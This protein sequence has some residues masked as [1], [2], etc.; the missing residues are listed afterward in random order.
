MTDIA[1]GEWGFDGFFISDDGALDNIYSAHHY[2]NSTYWAA[3]VAAN[4]GVNLD[5][6]PTPNSVFFQLGSAVG[7]GLVLSEN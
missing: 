7:N 1:R 4:A 3:V 6:P 5:L 2:V